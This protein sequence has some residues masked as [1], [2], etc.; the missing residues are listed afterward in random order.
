MTQFCEMK[1]RIMEKYAES[2]FISLCENHIEKK[3]DGVLPLLAICHLPQ[4]KI[5]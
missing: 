3:S 5:K 4:S 1:K 2:I